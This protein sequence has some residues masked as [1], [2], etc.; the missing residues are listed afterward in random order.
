MR[1]GERWG[2][3]AMA[4]VGA[5]AIWQTVDLDMWNF[6]G[7][8]PAMFPRFVGIALIGLAVLC[9]VLPRRESAPSE[10]EGVADYFAAAPGERRNF[11]CY[12]AA[13]VAVVPAVTWAGFWLTV[14]GLIIFLMRVAEGRALRTAIITG[15]IVATVVVACFGG[16]LHVSLPSGP[17]DDLLLRLVRTGGL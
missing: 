12:L 5:V 3:V 11:L 2:L 7:P 9:L 6:S 16:L 1:Q 14:F 15:A 10:D 4:A 13:L 17:I 8:G